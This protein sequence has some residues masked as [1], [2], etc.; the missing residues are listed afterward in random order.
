[1]KLTAATAHRISMKVNWVVERFCVALMAVLVVD[2]WLGI[3]ARYAKQEWLQALP[4]PMTFTE[5]L[6]RYLM[7]WMAL[8]AVSS[9]FA[10]REHIGVMFIFDRFPMPMKKWLSLAFDAIAFAFFAYLLINGIGFVERGFGRFTMIFGVPKG[11][12]YIGVPVAAAL[13]CIQLILVAFRDFMVFGQ[14][15]KEWEDT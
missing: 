15:E 9:C 5:E 4:I 14:A 1:M 8:L 11:I 6:A 3:M 10:Y 13:A 12:P 2:V 7:I